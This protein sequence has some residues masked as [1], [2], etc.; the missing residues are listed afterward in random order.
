MSR[1]L[2]GLIMYEDVYCDSVYFGDGSGI[3]VM[4]PNFY[5]EYYI[6]MFDVTCSY[7]D[8]YIVR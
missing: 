2:L 6:M 3:A 7:V 5:L 4:L 1:F 8:I